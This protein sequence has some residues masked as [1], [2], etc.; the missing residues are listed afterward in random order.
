MKSEQ[1]IVSQLCGINFA[2]LVTNIALTVTFRQSYYLDLDQHSGYLAGGSTVNTGDLGDAIRHIEVSTMNCSKWTK[3]V[4][5][6]P[7]R[8]TVFIGKERPTTSLQ[9]ILQSE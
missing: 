2:E 8:W 7:E 5:C 3:P 9:F 1:D 4:P 6:P